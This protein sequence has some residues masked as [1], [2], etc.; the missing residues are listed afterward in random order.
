[1]AFASDY[2]P[3]PTYQR[4]PSGLSGGG[5]GN[6]P[7]FASVQVTSVQPIMTDKTNSGRTI[8]RRN[9]Y[10]QWQI[11]INYNPMTRAEFDIINSFLLE[12]QTTLKPFK[13]KLP[14]YG[15][16]IDLDAEL[17]N[18]TYTAGTTSFVATA[19]DTAVA[20]GMLFHIVDPKDD[21]HTKAYKVTKVETNTSFDQ[22]NGTPGVGN[23]RVHFSPG[24]QKDVIVSGTQDPA[25]KFVT[26]EI[27][28][29]QKSDVVEYSLGTD[30]L[31]KFS[32]T[33]E[34][35]LA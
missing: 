12:R 19:A 34:E 5:A 24:F 8:R 28:V 4:L 3:D 29:Y 31:Y 9:M 10:H 14:Q 25:M 22:A 23:I 18:A 7:G 11:Q 27:R 20:P 13:V 30:G 2:L 6:G 16:G 15:A 26:P 35:A 32:L 33:L 21:L 17:V 1:M